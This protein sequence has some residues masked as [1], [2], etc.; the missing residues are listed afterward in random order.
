MTELYV[1]WDENFQQLLRWKTFVIEV[2]PDSV[3]EIVCH[4]DGEKRYFRRLFVHLG[5]AFRF[6]E[7]DVNLISVQTPLD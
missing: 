2:S 4:M 6:L 7:R 3:I 1:T 5:H